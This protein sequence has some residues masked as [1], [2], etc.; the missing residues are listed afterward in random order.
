MAIREVILLRH[1]H[2]DPAA[3]G[4]EDRARSLSARGIAEAEAVGAWLKAHR[5][6]PDRVLCSPAERT[7]ETLQQV[8][9]I[10][11]Y[12]DLRV[13]PRIYEASPVT[14][15]RVLDDHADA[16]RVLLVGHNPGLEDLVAL[17]ADGAS[18]A[19]RGLPPG[20]VVWLRLREAG[21]IEPDS[22][23]VLH[24]WWP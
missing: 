12:S 2:A 24:F 23:E 18:D 1:A 16:E 17:L 22:A 20:A 9:A 13:E 21:R 19:G 15:I 14:L 8:L 4:Q 10:T 7:R 6:D 3:L 5:A 11:G